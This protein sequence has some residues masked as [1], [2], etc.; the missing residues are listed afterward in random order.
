MQV[1]KILQT[2]KSI[3][4]QEVC[5][6]QDLSTNGRGAVDQ[7]SYSYSDPIK[8]YPSRFFNIY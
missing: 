4:A 5:D 6:Q 3:S 7:T 2:Q 8:T 1:R